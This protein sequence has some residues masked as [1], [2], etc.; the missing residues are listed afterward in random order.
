MRAMLAHRKPTRAATEGPPLRQEP[1]SPLRSMLDDDGHKLIIV[2]HR[3]VL[4]SRF[5]QGALGS[6]FSVPAPL[7]FVLCSC[8]GYAAT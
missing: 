1:A 6:W 7:F 8:S 4:G 3:L 2:E 5:A